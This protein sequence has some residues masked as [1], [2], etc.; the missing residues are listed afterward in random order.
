MWLKTDHLQLLPHFLHKL[1]P[2]WAGPFT[3][4]ERIGPVAYKLQLPPELSKLHPVFNSSHLKP[5]HGS[6]RS[7]QALAFVIDG[8]EEFEVE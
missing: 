8:A 5:H 6:G 1:A 4:L 2:K 7:G 3:I